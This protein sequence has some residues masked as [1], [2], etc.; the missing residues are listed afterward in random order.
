MRLA[1][2]GIEVQVICNPTGSGGRG[3]TGAMRTHSVDVRDESGLLR[4]FREVLPDAVVHLATV[5]SIPICETNRAF[6]LQVN[7]VGTECVLAAAEAA[8]VRMAVIASSGAV[9]RP[10]ERPLIEDESALEAVDNYGLTK[11]INERQAQF[12]AERTGGVARVARMY[13]AIGHDDPK[14]HLIPDILAQIPDGVRDAVIQ[15]GNTAPRRDYTHA[16][17]SASGL[18]ALLFNGD[19]LAPCEAFN[20][21]TGVEHSVLD[22]AETIGRHLGVRLNIVHDPTRVRPVDRMHQIGSTEKT[23]QRLGWEASISFH[24]GIRLVLEGLGRLPQSQ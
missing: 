2:R 23:R 11:L 12:W 10:T 22:V 8:E 15:L 3:V 1:Q 17:D 9:Y 5:N 6:A 7:V 19:V 21:C 18:E 4:V 14:S 20:L 16:D 24:D 13:N